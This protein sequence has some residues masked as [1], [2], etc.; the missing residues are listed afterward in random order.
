[1]EARKKHIRQKFFAARE[2]RVSILSIILLSFFSA[3]FFIYLIKTFEGAIRQNTVMAFVLVMVGY[4][5]VVILL[6]LFFAHRFVGPFDRLRYELDLVLAGDYSRRLKVRGQDDAYIRSFIEH[7]N[8]LIELTEV[9]SRCGAE[10]QRE[11][12][13][14]LSDI[15]REMEK[16]EGESIE[17]HRKELLGLREKLAPL[18]R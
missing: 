15:V 2:L 9:N 1:M 14:T 11:I 10:I 18:L 4:A 16:A 3:I 8:R 13:S 5:S 17:K 7:V 12:Y 6:T